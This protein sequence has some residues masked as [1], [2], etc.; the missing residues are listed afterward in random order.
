MFKVVSVL[1]ESAKYRSLAILG[2]GFSVVLLGAVALVYIVKAER[3]TFRFSQ[4][5]EENRA[6]A[7]RLQKLEELM[8][9]LNA[10]SEVIA[11]LNRASL[12]SGKAAQA[13]KLNQISEL[14]S[15][16]AGQNSDRKDLRLG[17]RVED[18]TQQ[19]SGLEGQLDSLMILMQGRADILTRLPSITPTTGILSSQFGMRVSPFSGEPVKHLGVDIGAAEGSAVVA[20]ADG[21]VV[22]VGASESYGKMLMIDHG[23]GVKTR[24]AHNSKIFVKKGQYVNRG[25]KISAVGSTGHSTGPHLH[26]EVLVDKKAR[27]PEAFL[28]DQAL[29]RVENS[30]NLSFAKNIGGAELASKG[31]DRESLSFKILVLKSK[32]VH[33][34]TESPKFWLGAAMM[35]LASSILLAMLASLLAQRRRRQIQARA[36][37]LDAYKAVTNNGIGDSP[38]AA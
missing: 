27:N 17:D 30:G 36:I 37:V 20:T 1:A 25:Q 18:L 28:V 7:D 6:V 29:A 21:F 15:K 11:D 16:Y 24:Y 12:A 33:Q 9:K 35:T 8:D 31:E 23:Y 19:I 2:L 14:I 32:I 4:A 38:K 26:Y 3:S 34:M 13:S 5:D 10:Y 22:D